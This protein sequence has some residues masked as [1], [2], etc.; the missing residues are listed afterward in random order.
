[1]LKKLN[2]KGVF[3]T[4]LT[5]A[6]IS[7]FLISYTIVT[8]KKDREAIN[9]RISSMNNFLFSFETDLSRQLYISGFRILFLYERRMAQTGSYMENASVSFD[10]VFNET[11]FNGSIYG[12]AEGE[13]SDLMHGAKFSD[14]V[15]KANNELAN[16]MNMDVQFINASISMTQDDPWRVKINLTSIL[17]VQD[18]GGL[19]SWNKNLSVASYIP[20]SEFEDPVYLI[21]T[22]GTI[23]HK[24]INK[25]FVPLNLSN[26]RL[27]LEGG[28]YI[29]ST[30]A[31]SFL[32]RFKGNLGAENKS[33]IFSFVYLPNISAQE[34]LTVR[35]GRAC[36]DYLYFSEVAHTAKSVSG[37]PGWFLLD[38]D[39]CDYFSIGCV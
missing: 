4:L 13:I 36:V 15:S 17:F 14:I 38:Q 5:I 33:G 18:K 6:L 34:G 19:A 1:M 20:I 26:L 22:R 8:I 10:N 11:F 31:P 9:K 25:S 27:A 7:L 16:K 32:D 2:K 30:F 3:F 21:N 23:P 12:S 35:T 39:N 28:Y 37:M 24:M 29:N